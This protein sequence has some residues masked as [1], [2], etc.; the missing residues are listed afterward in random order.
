MFFAYIGFDAV[1][2]TA[3]EC[4]NPQ[5]DLPV[6]ILSSL[7]ICTI[8]YI[9]TALVLTGLV[10]YTE[11]NV[12]NP[13]AVG[14]QATG[15]TWL[16][17]IIEIGAIAGLTSVMLVSLM[18]QPRIFYSM[19][20]DGLLPA[21]FA[22]VHP[23]FGTPHVTTITTGV[24]AAVLAGLLPVDVL[25]ELTSV[26]TL[27]AFTLVSLGVM[28]L[29]LRHPDAPR[30]FRV[31]FGPFVIPLL[32]VSTNLLLLSMSKGST[33]SRLFIWMALGVLIY[34]F[35]GRTHSYL[36]NPGRK[37]PAVDETHQEKKDGEDADLG[38]AD[39]EPGSDET[40]EMTPLTM[41]EP[42]TR[43]ENSK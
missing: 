6:G 5:R 36:N 19:A 27:F 23:R 21:V 17:P 14:I 10:P 26:G 1:S 38:S 43:Q 8:L 25:A 31:P 20:N 2:T 40:L 42:E 33:L 32:G 24:V 3:Q 9:F 28:I 35:Y 7:V 37:R 15:L 11:L 18:S 41:N 29:R 13:I 12:P 4:K 34:V 30:R 39:D 16:V 22:R